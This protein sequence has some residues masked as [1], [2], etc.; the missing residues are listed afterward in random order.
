LQVY[1][2]HN[3]NL[4]QAAEA[5]FVHRNTLIY[6]MERIPALTGANLDDPEIRLAMQLA[7]HIFRMMEKTGA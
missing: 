2:E 5:L 4:S 6:R 1:F 7:L 3:G